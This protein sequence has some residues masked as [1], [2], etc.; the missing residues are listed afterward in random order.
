MSYTLFFTIYNL[1]LLLFGSM[2]ITLATDDMG[3][4]GQEKDLL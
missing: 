4:L 1:E 3:L 2:L